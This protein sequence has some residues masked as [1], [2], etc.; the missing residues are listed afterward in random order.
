[1]DREMETALRALLDK[2]AIRECLLRYLRGIDRTDV[3]LIKSAFHEDAVDHHTR[4]VRG[5]IEGMLDWWLPQQ[6]GREATQHFGTNQTID[7]D[8][9]V[10]HVETYFF[11]FIKQT[12]ENEGALIGGRYAD[13][14]ERRGGVWKIALRVVIPEWQVVADARNTHW[15]SQ[16]GGAP[17]ARNRSDPSYQR[18]LR[19][20]QG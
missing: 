2:E 13:R 16:A 12:G 10:A 1:M 14:F 19:N 20:P 18:P 17:G 8:G 4:D 7:L 11:V 6:E 3:D 5:S 15:V 9:D